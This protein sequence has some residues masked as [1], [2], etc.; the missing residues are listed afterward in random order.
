[1]LVLERSGFAIID[2]VGLGNTVQL[3]DARITALESFGQ[4]C[5]RAHVLIARPVKLHA[6]FSQQ[7]L[8]IKLASALSFPVVATT[9][10]H[11][12]TLTNLTS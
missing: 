7:F 3:V 2:I 12:V 1:M 5:A 11:F 9:L 4:V 10:S 6:R 8:H